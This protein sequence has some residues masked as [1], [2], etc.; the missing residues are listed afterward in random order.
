MS[1]VSFEIEGQ[2]TYGLWKDEG[3]WIASLT[4]QAESVIAQLDKE[5]VCAVAVFER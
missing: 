2:K 3:H 1:F 4:E 5:D